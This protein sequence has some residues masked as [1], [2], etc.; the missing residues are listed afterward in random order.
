MKPLTPE[1]KGAKGVF[2]IQ[3]PICGVNFSKNIS[4]TQV[5]VNDRKN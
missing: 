1:A 5:R 2:E 3:S 4:I